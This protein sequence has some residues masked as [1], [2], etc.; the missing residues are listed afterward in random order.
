M[1]GPAEL[2]ATWLPYADDGSGR[3]TLYEPLERTVWRLVA[4][5][6]PLAT[7]DGIRHFLETIRARY[8]P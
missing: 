2:R 3:L 1:A 4:E 7:V 6:A 8:E 5:Y